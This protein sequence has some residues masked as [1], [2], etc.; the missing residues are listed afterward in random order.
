MATRRVDMM[1]GGRPVVSHIFHGRNAREAKH[2]E[3]SH[4]KADRSLDAAI[5]GK[6]Y[7]GIKIRAR[8]RTSRG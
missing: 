8:R 3:M 4:R 7:R 6:P 2:N 5:R 1:E